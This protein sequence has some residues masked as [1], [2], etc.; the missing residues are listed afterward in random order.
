MHTWRTLTVQEKS[1]SLLRDRDGASLLGSR[2]AALR[3]RAE[4]GR[5]GGPVATP[6]LMVSKVAGVGPHR[7]HRRRAYSGP[8]SPLPRLHKKPL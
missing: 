8:G 1:L 7:W 5:G 3:V 6:E 2:S 4:M